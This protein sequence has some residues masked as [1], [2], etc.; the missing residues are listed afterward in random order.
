MTDRHDLGQRREAVFD[1][2]LGGRADDLHPADRREAEAFWDWLGEQPR[3]VTEQ[4]RASRSVAT[5]WTIAAALA[6]MMAASTPFWVSGDDA[7][8][9]VTRYAAGRAERKVIRL[10][11][12]STVTL[13]ARTT[14]T[15]S[16]T[17]DRRRLMLEGGEALFEVAHDQR[18]PFVVQTPFG[19]V[20][21]VGTAFDVAV[22]RRDADVSV[23]QGTVRVTVAVDTPGQGT[24][25]AKLARKGER[26]AFGT[27]VQGGTRMG[28]ISQAES[29][30]TADAVAWTRGQ[31][32]FHG[33][34]LEDVIDMVNRYAVRASDELTLT[35]RRAARIPVFGIVDQGNPAAIRDLIDN[36]HAVTVRPIRSDADSPRSGGAPA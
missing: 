30:G 21:A 6:L 34:P 29:V 3:P 14:L 24:P 33:E 20:T 15:V 2:L 32:V 7:A 10:K 31:L 8:A 12:G 28:F 1:A 35:D 11:D 9:S 17:P 25:V 18:R 4:P 22:G 16:F 27:A 13:A 36:P 19:A 26:V 5:R 23:T